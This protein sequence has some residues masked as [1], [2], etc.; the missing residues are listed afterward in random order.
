MSRDGSQRPVFGLA[1]HYPMVTFAPAPVTAGNPAKA[2][3]NS[4]AKLISTSTGSGSDISACTGKAKSELKG[5][6]LKDTMEKNAY[7][8]VMPSFLRV[9]FEL[10]LIKNSAPT[11]RSWC[12]CAEGDGYGTP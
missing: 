2:R 6:S 3:V 8:A 1:H 5:R 11:M 12:L 10:L 9:F 7:V 4:M